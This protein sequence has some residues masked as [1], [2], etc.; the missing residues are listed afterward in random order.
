VYANPG[1][2]VCGP[3]SCTYRVCNNENPPCC[4]TA[5][6]TVTVCSTDAVD[7][8]ARVC[9]GSTVTVPVLNNDTTCCGSVVAS[10]LAFVGT[11]PP[12][13]SIVS[14][15]IRY[16]NSG[17]PNCGP[18]SCTYRVC[19]NETP[20]CCDTATLTVTVCSVDAQDDT[21]Q[22]CAGT[23]LEIDVL[24]NDTTCCG[25]LVPSSLAFVGTPPPGFSIANGRVVYANPGTPTSGT[26][27]ATYRVCNAENPPCCDTATVCVTICAVDA[28]DDPVTICCGDV[29]TVANILA[30]DVSTCGTLNCKQIELVPP[31][32]PGFSIEGCTVR[33]DSRLGGCTSPAVLRY[34][35]RGGTGFVC[36]DEANVVV[37]ILSSPTAVDDKFE[38]LPTTQFPVVIRVLDN[39]LPGAGCT[40]PT[41][42][43]CPAG[44]PCAVQL[45][46]LPSHGTATVNPDCTITFVPS[47]SFATEDR[48]CY[49][50]TNSCD[51]SDEGCV[52]ISACRDID[53][54]QCGS[55]LLYPE[56]DNRTAAITLFTLTYGCCEPGDPNLAV[57]FRFIDGATCLETDRTFTLTPC[58]TLSF[59]TSTVNPNSTRG[60]AYA[61]AKRTTAGPGNPNGMPIVANKLI[62]Q[63][64]VID[65]FE[66]LD[67]GLN[68]VS[69]LGLGQ[70]G[71][72]NDDDQDGIRDLNGPLDPLAEYEQAPDEILVPRFL[73]QDPPGTNALFHSQLLLLSLT[74]GSAFTTTVRFQIYTDSEDAL[75]Q[76][77]SFY[78]WDKR[79]LIDWSP[80]TL[81]AFLMSVGD[82]PEEII[83]APS[84]TAGWLR[85]DGLVASSTQEQIDDPAIYAVLIDS[86]GPYNV[87]DLPFEKCTQ[88]NGDLLPSSP[89]GDGPVPVAD[90]DQ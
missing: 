24:A 71:A 22:V 29:A 37:T 55:L 17:T 13:F 9:A 43:G 10:S 82:D 69:F 1:T 87:A 86:F 26:V 62:G 41:C 64:L 16:A 63:M 5:T 35:V 12:G 80:S 60:Y 89:L 45:T 70:P 58:D 74:G 40:F 36:Q 85:I 4:D 8:T 19:N 49:R 23:T 28:V 34:R 3:V 47:P 65:G 72:D 78:C 20:P 14:G 46:K 52:E 21:A 61:F 31:V 18:V 83:G 51:C 32:A 53:R 42:T 2:P 76:D 48:F 25:S 81:N 68:A 39:D 90:D 15:Q 79:P 59:L 73:G 50:V 66:A 6:V 11:P 77:R 56:Y 7:D 88:A 75:S 57:E 54:R 44:T 30:N 27:C 38:V 33:Y 67:Y 84:R